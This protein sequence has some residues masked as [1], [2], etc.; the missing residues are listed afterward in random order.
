MMARLHEITRGGSVL[1][2]LIFFRSRRSY[3]RVITP[4]RVYA[5]NP[6][7]L[8]TVALMEEGQ[9]HARQVKAEIKQL[10][11][12]LVA[13][14]SRGWAIYRRRGFSPLLHDPPGHKS[15]RRR[16]VAVHKQGRKM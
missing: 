11:R 16:P 10:A 12:M 4:V 14:H 7:L 2:P 1:T 15:H 9:E 13:W 8:L 3:G 5:L 6:G